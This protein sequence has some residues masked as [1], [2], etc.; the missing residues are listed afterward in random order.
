[1][2][3]EGKEGIAQV[4]VRALGNMSARDEGDER[5][6][7]ADANTEEPTT[8]STGGKKGKVS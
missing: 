2:G 1:M 5:P 6:E 3:K 8:T 7:A 4:I